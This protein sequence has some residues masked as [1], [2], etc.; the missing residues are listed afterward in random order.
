MRSRNIRFQPSWL[1]RL[2]VGGLRSSHIL[3]DQVLKGGLATDI[4]L[5][6]RMCLRLKQVCE[7]GN[8]SLLP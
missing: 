5:V 8:L 6:G 1:Y 4:N 3:E 2:V 7:L